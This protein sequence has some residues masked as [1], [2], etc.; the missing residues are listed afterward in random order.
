MD[1]SVIRDVLQRPY[2]A[3]PWDRL[4][5]AL[6]DAADHSFGRYGARDRQGYE[7]RPRG[8]AAKLRGAYCIHIS[9]GLSRSMIAEAV[10]AD[11]EVSPSSTWTLS[12][13]PTVKSVSCAARR[14]LIGQSFR[15]CNCGVATMTMSL[16]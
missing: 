1:D 12:L 5:T 10:S 4:T 14:I 13:R 16:L 11:E 6:R 8:W 3:D 15:P 9:N 7:I 2:F